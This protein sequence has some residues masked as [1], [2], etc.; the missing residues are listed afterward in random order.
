MVKPRFIYPFICWWHL[1]YF[2]FFTVIDKA[3]VNIPVQVSV[4]AFSRLYT[5]RMIGPYSK[6]KIPFLRN[7]QIVFKSGGPTLHSVKQDSSSCSNIWYGQ[8]FKILA[9]V[10]GM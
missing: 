4:G 10:I 7:G 6:C 9:I 5:S 3:V 2:Q 1:S 8:S